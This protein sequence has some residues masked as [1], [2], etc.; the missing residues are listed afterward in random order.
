MSPEAVPLA[1]APAGYARRGAELG[2]LRAAGP[3][4]RAAGA[5]WLP[6]NALETLQGRPVEPPCYPTSE[7]EPILIADSPEPSPAPRTP[8]NP[9]H[10]PEGTTPETTKKADHCSHYAALEKAT[11]PNQTRKLTHTDSPQKA[12]YRQRPDADSDAPRTP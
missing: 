3:R 9:I 5:G 1:S 11:T 2:G 12:Y 6:L 7:G 4:D 8:D 10:L